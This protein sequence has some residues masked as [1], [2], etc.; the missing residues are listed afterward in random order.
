MKYVFKTHF[1]YRAA[2][3]IDGTMKNVGTF[4]TPER[5]FLAV[6]LFLYWSKTFHVSEIPRK[7]SHVDALNEFGY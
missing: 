3:R 7:P 4:S 5:A 6:R 2:P 1:G